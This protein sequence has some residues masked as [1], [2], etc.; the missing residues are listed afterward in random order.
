[1]LDCTDMYHP[2]QPEIFLDLQD[3][4]IAQMKSKRK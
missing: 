4:I 1:M 2:T 3:E